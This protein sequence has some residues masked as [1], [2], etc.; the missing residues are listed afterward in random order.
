M[1]V[2]RLFVG[3]F[4]ATAIVFNFAMAA[5]GGTTPLI[6]TALLDS[7]SVA[8]VDN[9]A[10]VRSDSMHPS[11]LVDRAHNARVHL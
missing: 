4:T 6:A 10:T 2:W 3:R 1:N 7:A 11:V 9:S 8:C 5:F